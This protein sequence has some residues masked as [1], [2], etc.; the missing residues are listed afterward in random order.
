M[1]ATK[2]FTMQDVAEHNT[3]KD[4]YM[5]VHEKVYDCTKF[6]DEHPGGE[7]VMLDVAGQ[8]ATEA[9]EDVG[10]SDEA[11]EVL[12]GLLVGELKR[13]PGEEGPKRQIANSNQG[14]GQDPTG[15][16]LT[17]YALVVAVGFAAYMGY[18]YLQ[19]QNEAQGSA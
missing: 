6:L 11:R 9:F 16:S 19:K 12:D 8:D 15:S 5:V 2:E 13:L 18:N 3:S 14:S 10:H 4:I 7:E 1:S 17:S